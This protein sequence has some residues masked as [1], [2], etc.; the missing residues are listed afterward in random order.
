MKQEPSG[1]TVK[2]ILIRIQVDEQQ[3]P[4][5][6]SW[7]ADDAG[8]GEHSAKAMALRFWDEQSS[9]GMHIDLWTGAMTVDEMNAF[10]YQTLLELSESYRRATHDASGSSQ[11]KEAASRFARYVQGKADANPKA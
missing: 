6:I 9:N 7:Q 1:K 3:I 11:L 4:Q 10:V 2:N 5:A 8:P